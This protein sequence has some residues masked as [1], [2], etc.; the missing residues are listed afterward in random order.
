[1]PDIKQPTLTSA[2]LPPSMQPSAH[3][4][5][6]PPLEK[7]IA[8]GD[9]EAK[10]LRPP[11]FMN[12]KPK[13]PN[14]SLFFGNRAVGEKE[15]GMR[16]DQ[17]IT[18][19]FRPAVPTEILTMDN[20]PIP[21]SIVRDGRIMFGDLIL[22][23]I[24]KADY[25]GSQKWNE[26]TAR[27]RVKKPGVSIEGDTQAADGRLA[28]KDNLADVVRQGRGKVSTYVPQLAEVDSKTADNSGPI[29]LA[30]K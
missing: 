4:S 20:K 5:I 24:P 27:L 19:G 18:M 15:S 11:N 10:P 21:P 23:I 13:N 25:I 7:E 16:Y 1:M 30:E 22:L 17:L 8:Y 2:S 26:Q 29:N 9:I 3:P 6:Q 14:M 28:P 12:L